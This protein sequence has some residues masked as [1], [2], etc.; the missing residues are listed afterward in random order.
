MT[1]LTVWGDA[2]NRALAR[3]D[4]HGYAAYLAD[5]A[6]ERAD[7][8]ARRMTELD[9]RARQLMAAAFHAVFHDRGDKLDSEIADALRTIYG[10]D[11]FKRAAE[12]ARPK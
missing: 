6:Q 4:D 10:D 1:T 7:R 9:H 8:R 11:A 3:G 2:Y 5:K 12:L